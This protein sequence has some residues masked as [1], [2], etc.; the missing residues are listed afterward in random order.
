[1]LRGAVAKWRLNTPGRAWVRIDTIF[2]DRQAVALGERKAE[3]V[4]S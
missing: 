4:E 2:G 1:V 3:D